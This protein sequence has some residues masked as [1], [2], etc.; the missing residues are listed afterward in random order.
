[1]PPPATEMRNAG[2]EQTEPAQSTPSAS[3]IDHIP[4]PSDPSP[5]LPSRQLSDTVRQS[6]QLTAMTIVGNR[7]KYMGRA[8]Q[9]H[10]RSHPANHECKTV[11]AQKRNGKR[12]DLY[13]EILLLL[14]WSAQVTVG[15][16]VADND[17]IFKRAGE[18]QL[19]Q[20]AVTRMQTILS[21][22]GETDTEH[23]VD[24]ALREEEVSI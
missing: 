24:A 7:D 5:V 18:P 12:R 4:S 8:R 17:I 13:L 16:T 23:P 2:G 19:D 11:E 20:Q 1:M 3:P 15:E 22:L 21:V 6:H 10:R 14:G 9:C